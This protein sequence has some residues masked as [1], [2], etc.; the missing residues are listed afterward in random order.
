[1]TIRNFKAD[2]IPREI[3]EEILTRA[4]RAPSGANSQPWEIW[5]LGG[6]VMRKISDANVESYMSGVAPHCDI[7]VKE[8]SGPT[9][10]RA[11]ETG[12]QLY[13]L[14][15]I[16]W[17]KK[18]ERDIWWSHNYRFFGAPNTIIVT[19]DESLDYWAPLSCAFLADH[20]CLLALEY[21][22][23]TSMQRAPID[24]PENIR[25]I[26]GMPESKKMVI[27]IA[28]G[29]PDWEHPAN[30]MRTGREPLESVSTWLGF[31]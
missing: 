12:K 14:V 27:S 25:R 24:Y 11:I 3:L 8:P 29:Y 7:P 6:D 15:G 2:P 31:D 23:A 18:E 16:D 26:T 10:K 21:G 22:L 1:M 20:I 4:L 17:F 28:I 5:V 13:T 19:W 30:K 9:K